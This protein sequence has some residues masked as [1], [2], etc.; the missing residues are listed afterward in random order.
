[1]DKKTLRTKFRERATCGAAIAAVKVMT[2]G[3]RAVGV[4]L[5]GGRVSPRGTDKQ[6]RG[7]RAALRGSEAIRKVRPAAA[8][9]LPR[10]KAR[11]PRRRRRPLLCSTAARHFSDMLPRFR[12]AVRQRRPVRR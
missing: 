3:G 11:A 6:R 2:V 10:E 8:L 5:V 7:G 4:D 9:L 1:M 12:V